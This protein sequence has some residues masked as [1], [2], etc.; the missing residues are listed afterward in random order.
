MFGGEFERALQGEPPVGPVLDL[1]PHLVIEDVELG[2]KGTVRDVLEPGR[3]NPRPGVLDEVLDHPHLVHV[4]VVVHLVHLV[5]PGFGQVLLGHHADGVGAEDDEILIVPV[6]AED[7]IVGPHHHA[8]DDALFLVLD[9]IQVGG[10][11]PLLRKGEEVGFDG[12]DVHQGNTEHPGF[13]VRHQGLIDGPVQFCH[14]F[15]FSGYIVS[16]YFVKNAR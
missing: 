5:L 13:L 4:F 10:F 14:C 6:P 9:E 3:G 15:R 8:P 1:L 2:E 11:L 16:Q 7:G 12:G